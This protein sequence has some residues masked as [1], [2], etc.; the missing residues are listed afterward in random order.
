MRPLAVM[1]RPGL[2]RPRPA[3]S[4]RLS[5]LFSLIL[6][7]SVATI[8]H[9]AIDRL[10]FRGRQ[11]QLVTRYQPFE[12][13]GIATGSGGWQPGVGPLGALATVEA[14]FNRPEVQGVIGKIEAASLG[15]AVGPVA[16][17]PG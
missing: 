5:S 13:R 14:G 10:L 16:P 11:C 12:T 9:D 17:G 6:S 7:V 15:P 4:P 1:G 2:H 8:A 3:P